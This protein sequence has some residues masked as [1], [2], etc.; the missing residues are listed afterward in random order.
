MFK[1]LNKGFENKKSSFK[2][3]LWMAWIFFPF[4]ILALAIDSVYF[5][6]NYFDGRIITNFLVLIYYLLFFRF[7]DGELRKLFFIM[8][9]L[10]YLGEIIFC[11]WF[12]MYAYRTNDIPFYI[13]FGHA[14]VYGSGYVFS[15]TNWAIQHTKS[16]QKFFVMSFIALFLGVYFWLNDLFSLLLGVLFFIIIIRKWGQ[17]VYFFIALC[18]IYVEL[19]GTY[20][21]CWAYILEIVHLIPSANP[22]VG[23]VF[24]YA[25]GD[26]L[27]VKIAN[28]WSRKKNKQL[29]LE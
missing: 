18:A 11:K 9:F 28:I 10:S 12:E 2:K 5:L 17:N 8:I 6:E 27:L 14:I 26:V 19:L 29:N 1:K 3:Q 13:P 16:L 22:P 23:A 7:A 24:I 4:T 15:K 25:G 21:G 20:L